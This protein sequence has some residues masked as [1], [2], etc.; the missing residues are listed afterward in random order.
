[1]P[2][3]YQSTDPLVLPDP[4]YNSKL[5]SKLINKIMGGG[6]KTTAQKVFYAAVDLASKKWQTW[7]RPI[8]SPRRSRT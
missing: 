4:I 2:R 6:K 5:A 1:M 7:R 3:R 8:S